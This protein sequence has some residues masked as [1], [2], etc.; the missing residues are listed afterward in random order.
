MSEENNPSEPHVPEEGLQESSET[1]VESAPP[2]QPPK[3]ERPINFVLIKQL[4]YILGLILGSFRE[5]I[6][7]FIQIQNSTDIQKTIKQIHSGI[8]LK[9]YNIWILISSA[10]LACIGLDQ[11]SQAVIIGAML[12]SPL[13]SPILGIG[14]SIGMNDRPTLGRSVY[15][16]GTAVGISLGT[17]VVYF[18]ITPLGQPTEELLA[19]TSPTLLD[20]MVGFFGGVA[21]IV[22]SSRKEITNAIPGVAIAT[23][24][25]PPLCT[26]GY[27]IATF[28]FDFFAGAF[29]LFF[30]NVVFISLSTFLIIRFLNFP[31]VAEITLNLRKNFLRGVVIFVLLILF[32]AG[33]LFVDLITT[34]RNE[35][36][37]QSFLVDKFPL[38]DFSVERHELIDRDTCKVLKITLAGSHYIPQDTI[39]DWEKQLHTRYYMREGTQLLLL[40][41][42]SDP[43]PM[44]ALYSSV[45]AE[46]ERQTS[47]WEDDRDRWL[48]DRQE[49]DRLEEELQA[50]REGR[51]PIPEI[52]DEIQA[53][54]PELR[55][56][57]IG[58]MRIA[59]LGKPNDRRNLS[60]DTL[61]LVLMFSWQDTVE[62][63]VLED[64]K[65]LLRQRLKERY[66]VLNVQMID[67]NSPFVRGTEEEAEDE[68]EE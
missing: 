25:M 3:K 14:L 56:L 31:L 63:G 58:E 57:Q 20:V 61:A 28:R 54:T 64:R 16:F 11:N 45:N 50:V 33:W 10:V 12:I 24:L 7:K 13:M 66:N 62:A 34:Q 35:N 37:I 48:Q 2:V 21:G 9:G 19:R 38:E 18:A 42:A 30:L 53:Y 23:A 22:A 43:A 67:R 41:T 29:Y 49:I 36:R 5:V 4:V 44:E 15:N 65:S 52:R 51:L 1:P 17:A 68:S 26:A 8:E 46:I 39:R 60:K 55:A 40:Q 59:D 47:E 6:L 27:G 32:P